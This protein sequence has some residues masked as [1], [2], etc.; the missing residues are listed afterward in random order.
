[1]KNTVVCDVCYEVFFGFSELLKHKEVCIPIIRHVVLNDN[2]DIN[3]S[4]NDIVLSTDDKVNHP[5]YYNAGKIEVIDFIEDQQLDFHL[6]CVVKYICRAKHKL[7]ELE[8]LEKGLWYL[9]RKVDL[10]KGNAV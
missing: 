4:K 8:D 9:Q 1:V 10:M 7:Q 3:T 2:G 5:S 6:G